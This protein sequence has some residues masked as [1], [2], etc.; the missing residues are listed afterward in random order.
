MA[1]CRR[2]A[3]PSL[4]AKIRGLALAYPVIHHAEGYEQ[5]HRNALGPAHEKDF[6]EAVKELDLDSRVTPAHVPTYLYT[7]AE[8]DLVPVG[9]SF[10]YAQ[11]LI[12]CKVPCSLHV[13]PF[14]RHG[15]SCGDEEIANGFARRKAGMDHWC[16]ECADFLRL[17]CEEP[18]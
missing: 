8:D 9:N 10:R 1:I 11:A 4:D 6:A 18:F 14:G 3:T 2:L 16:E 17:Y 7:T 15:S 12:R 5:T 13:Y